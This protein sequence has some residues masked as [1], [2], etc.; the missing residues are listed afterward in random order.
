[1]DHV[2]TEHGLRLT[3]LCDPTDIEELDQDRILEDLAD[4]TPDGDPLP[5]L[6]RNFLAD[7]DHLVLVTD[8]SSGRYLAFLAADNGATTRE[9][10]LLLET[11]F[12]TP[13]ARGQNLL[14]RMIALAVL[15]IG[16]LRAVPSVIAA[17]TRHPLCY[18]TMRE[19]ARRVTGARFLPDPE[20]VAINFHTATLAQRIA[21]EIRPSRRFQAATGTISGGMMMAAGAGHYRPLARDPQFDRLQPAD[22]MLAVLDLRDVAE[23][24]IL[25][26]ARRIYRSR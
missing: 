5:W 2:L 7:Y 1:M 4:D 10:F 24:S 14:R 11:A 6:T 8:R 17:S 18:R 13:A 12:V 9:D 22:K 20:S 23:A 25:D 19:T 26:D 3:Y 15:R 21:R 16:G